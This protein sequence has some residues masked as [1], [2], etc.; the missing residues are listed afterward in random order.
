MYSSNLSDNSICFLAKD[1]AAVFEKALEWINEHVKCEWNF[2][3]FRDL[4]NSSFFYKIL[5]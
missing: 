2:D 1:I 5:F 3:I 4:E